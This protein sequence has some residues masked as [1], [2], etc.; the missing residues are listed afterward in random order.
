MK[1]ISFIKLAVLLLLLTFSLV[2]NAFSQEAI[3]KVIA[4]VGGDMILSSDIEQ[5]VLRLKMQ[6]GLPE[7]DVKCQLLE[8]LL[9]QK[10]LLHQSRI[11]S[12]APN[13]AAIESEI[14]RRLRYFVNQIGSEK[15]LENYFHKPMYEIKNDLR[16]T[17]REQQLTQQMRQKVVEKITVTPSE[18]KSFFKTI[19]TDSL[20][21]IPQQYELQQIAIY[22]PS[23]AI[24]KFNVK[25]KL[26]DLR[27]RILKGER[28]SMLAMAYSEDLASAKKGGELGFRTRDELVKSFSEVAFNLADGQVS[29]IVETEYGFHIIQMIEKRNNQVNVRHIL[30]KPQFSSDMLIEARNKLDSIAELVRKDSLTFE[31]ACVY[32]SEDKKSRMNGGVVVNAATNT[33][34]FEKEQLQPSDYYIIKELK[35]GEVSQSFESRDEN[36]N[37]IFKVVKIKNIIPSHKAN[38]VDDYN[39]IQEMTKQSREYDVFMKWIKEKQRITYVKI[40]PEFKNCKFPTEGWVK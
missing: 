21:M 18:V 12:L 25:D 11:D 23:T 10:L 17:I 8:Q 38:L 28:F 1:K 4:V 20:P 40:E 2:R 5:E 33:K 7:G 26:L 34:Y 30:L 39:T 13:E 36:A 32:H 3:D 16:E 31:K 22:P 35:K 24:A 29:Q 6:G 37:V 14:E 27:S 15:A 9:I 19:P